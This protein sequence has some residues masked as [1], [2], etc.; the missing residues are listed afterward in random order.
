[1]CNNDCKVPRKHASEM[2]IRQAEKNVHGIDPSYTPTSLPFSSRKF[3]KVFNE[4]NLC[5][6]VTFDIT[7][8]LVDRSVYAEQAIVEQEIS[9][10][11]DNLTC[12]QL[13]LVFSS[14][15]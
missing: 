9:R 1:M 13:I 4:N 10:I 2:L 11:E 14:Y 6:E 15:Y 12:K 8:P 5:S 7:Q 3:K